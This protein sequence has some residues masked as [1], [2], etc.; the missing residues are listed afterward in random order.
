MTRRLKRKVRRILIGSGIP[1]AVL[2]LFLGIMYV[3]SLDT[4]S[5]HAFIEDEDVP[6]GQA[7]MGRAMDRR[8]QVYFDN[9][10]LLDRHL[11]PDGNVSVKSRLTRL[12]SVELPLIAA[13]DISLETYYDQNKAWLDNAT[14]GDTYN[15]FRLIYNKVS[16][17]H[18]YERCML[19]IDQ[20][21][22]DS[23]DEKLHFDLVV[24]YDEML[25]VVY[26]VEVNK[27]N[28]DVTIQ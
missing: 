19:T 17:V 20:L 14:G 27:E 5:L 16:R 7:S 11:P 21:N 6:L 25:E 4:S 2:A 15:D 9:S 10:P 8:I 24:L 12:Y 26:Y 13:A 23:S 22:V 28:F 3:S 18:D 1:L